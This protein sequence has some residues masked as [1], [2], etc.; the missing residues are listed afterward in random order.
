MI[1]VVNDEIEISGTKEDI[2]DDLSNT[3][4]HLLWGDTIKMSEFLVAATVAINE[5]E[6][7]RIKGVENEKNTKENI[8]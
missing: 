5:L 2:L 3:I 6:K 8:L 4:Y 1:K 7:D